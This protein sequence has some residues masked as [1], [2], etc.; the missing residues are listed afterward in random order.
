LEVVR[1]VLQLVGSHKAHVTNWP[2]LAVTAIDMWG[3][4]PVRI[5]GVLVLL[6]LLVAYHA[7]LWNCTGQVKQAVP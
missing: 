6:L 4:M 5:T 7:G 2:P 3:Y 1:Q